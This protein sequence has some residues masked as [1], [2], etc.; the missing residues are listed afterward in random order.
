MAILDWCAFT[1]PIARTERQP[2]EHEFRM[3]IVDVTVQMGKLFPTLMKH[4]VADLEVATPQRPYRR[5]WSC[6]NIGWRINADWKREE[7]L[8]VFNGAACDLLRKIGDEAQRDILLQAIE[9]GSRIDLATDVETSL[10]IKEIEHAG[11]A[12]RITSTGFISSHTGDTLYIGS[13]KSGAFAR[14]YRYAPPHPRSGLLRIEHELKKEQARAVA[15]IA[16]IHGVDEA[17]RSVAAKFNYQHPLLLEVFAGTS[18]PIVTERHERTMART[19]IWLMTQ[20]APAFQ[21]LVRDGV[22]TDPA[23]WVKKYML[24]DA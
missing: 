15:K 1:L 14:V 24:G 7:V 17:Q 5:A 3:R 19:E 2:S 6:P 12:K 9:S 8:I 20:A 16:A 18:S 23:A 21:R 10:D 13:R 4:S 11:W 22:I